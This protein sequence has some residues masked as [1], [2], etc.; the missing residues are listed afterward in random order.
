MRLLLGEIAAV[1]VLGRALA[2]VRL[3]AIGAMLLLL[4]RRRRRL[5]GRAIAIVGRVEDG[6]EVHG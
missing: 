6:T 3:L 5:R 4:L 2:W 1:S